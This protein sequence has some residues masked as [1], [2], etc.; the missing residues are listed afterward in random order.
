MEYF[1]G[2][3]FGTSNSTLSVN[4]DGNVRLLE[5]DPLS[6]TPFSLKSVL[7]YDED[8]RILRFGQDAING[9][10]DNDACGRY[11]QSIKSYLPDRTFQTTD[12]AGKPLDII[13]IIAIILREIK[14]RGEAIIDSCVDKVV[15]GRPAVF[16]D[17]PSIDK[18]AQDRLIAAANKAGF[19]EIVIQL[20]PV[21][22]ALSNMRNYSSEE[23][24]VLVGDF[25]GG[26]SD[27]A[28]VKIN[29][30]SNNTNKGIV[31][32]TSG[33]YVGGNNFDSKI[34]WEKLTPFF[35]RDAKIR[36]MDGVISG[37][38]DWNTM[39][40]GILRELCQWHNI[41]RLKT[42]K[43]MD[44]LRG[45][46]Y[47]AQDSDK[48]LID[49]LIHL[50]EDNYGYM[51]FRSIEAAKILLSKDEMSQIFFRERK[52]IVEEIILREEFEDMLNEFVVKISTSVDRVIK[53]AGI[54]NA[55]VNTVL[56]TG[57]S[58]LIPSIGRIF[59]AR[60]GNSKILSADAFT[61]VA[62]GLGSESSLL[63]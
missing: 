47:L 36:T 34:M 39:P 41:P 1:F 33:V 49:N 21:A 30:C 37:S 55:D 15:L 9:Y 10:L 42:P 60:F 29:P 45:Y 40:V 46:Q 35:G 63:I 51:L 53:D 52:L 50:I 43:N 4:C 8:E 58:S 14:R 12:I 61:S 24:I 6:Q 44:T 13:D 31:L 62:F 38:G 59:S 11:I 3:D 27:F 54:A 22:A 26:T 28:V 5:I 19:S 2:L 7:F 20:E 16:S 48:H 18:L 56:L 25:G 17:D 23:S 32:A 57:G